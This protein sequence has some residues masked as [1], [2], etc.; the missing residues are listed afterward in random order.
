MN[1]DSFFGRAP[2]VLFAKSKRAVVGGTSESPGPGYTL[3]SGNKHAHGTLFSKDERAINKQRHALRAETVGP[4][5]YQTASALGKQL[6]SFRKNPSSFSFGHDSRFMRSK[7]DE[8]PGPGVY[9][10]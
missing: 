3:E 10:V 5:E 2:A 7:V 6:L 1:C 4:G 8:T 9:T